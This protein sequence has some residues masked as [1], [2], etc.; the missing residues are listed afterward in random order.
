MAKILVTDYTKT[1]MKSLLSQS[2]SSMTKVI[3][4]MNEKYPECRSTVQNVSNKLS[5][6]TLRLS[7]AEAMAR[8]IGYTLRL[9]KVEE[10]ESTVP[11]EEEKE[12]T[13]KANEEMVMIP[14]SALQGM[15]IEMMKYI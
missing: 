7:E 9:V 1:M 12:D 11:D 4:T 5:K 15:V 14:R 6:G 3:D 10:F 2:G 8:S 13:D